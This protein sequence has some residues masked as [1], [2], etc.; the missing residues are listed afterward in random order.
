M[1]DNGTLNWGN[2]I[3]NDDYSNFLSWFRETYGVQATRLINFHNYKNTVYYDYW[4]K[5]GKPRGQAG[6][7]YTY[8]T[9]M[10]KPATP[11]TEEQPSARQ[12]WEAAGGKYLVRDFPNPPDIPLPEGQEW[13]KFNYDPQ[14]MEPLPAGEE[15][16]MP[17][18]VETKATSTGAKWEIKQIGGY[19]V[20]VTYDANGNPI[21]QEVLGRTEHPT[22]T[23]Q[24]TT[25]PTTQKAEYE[26]WE[27]KMTASL[28]SPAVWIKRWQVMRYPTPPQ[29]SFWGTGP[30]DAS[31]AWNVIAQQAKVVAQ[32]NAAQAAQLIASGNIREARD[33]I[34]QTQIATETA[35][36]A[37]EQSQKAMAQAPQASAMASMI[38]ANPQPTTPPAPKWL[39]QFVEGQA[40]GQPVEKKPVTTPSGQLW[41]KTPWSVREGL[42]GYMEWAGYRPYR[43]ML[44]QMAMMQP[45][46]PKGVSRKR[47]SPAMQ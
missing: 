22:W 43:D 21:D 47:W 10:A 15:V 16:W 41:N 40:A 36:R 24:P 45:G 35:T 38:G 1:P 46:S 9:G 14:T 18:P 33:L 23:P 26:A 44:E 32:A 17:A 31:K 2:M 11:V 27:Q 28:T 8:W 29:Q 30:G 3:G 7:P 5:A 19:D 39:P 25:Q 13:K 34:R 42:R 12:L 6:V 20:A 37:E 4:V